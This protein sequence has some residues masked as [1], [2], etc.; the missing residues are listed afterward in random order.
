MLDQTET[1]NPEGNERA[2]ETYD[3][4]V[5]GAG[6]AGLNALY[7]ATDYLPKGAKVLLIDQNQKAGGMWNAAYDYVRL[8]QPHPMF[9]IGDI[10]WPWTKPATYLAKRDEIR[11]HLAAAL[12]PISQSVALETRFGHTVLSC[13]EVE[14]AEGHRARIRFHANDDP[15]RVQTVE[16]ATAIY[17]SGLDYREAEPLALS[18]GSVISIIPQDLRA[19]LAAKPAA[20]V[21]VVG[22]GKTGMDTVLETLAQDPGRPVSLINGTGTNFMNRTKY[23]PT[24]LRRWFSGEPFSRLLRDLALTFDGDNE[25]QTIEHFRRTHSTDPDTPN[26]AFLFA[27]QSVAEDARV[28]KGVRQKYADYLVDV[29]DGPDGPRMELRSGTAEPVEPGSIFVNCTGSYFRRKDLAD[30][31][32]CL[33][34]HRTVLSITPRDGLHYHTGVSGFFATHLFYRGELTDLGL[35]TIDFEA[36]F[37]ESKNAFVGA[38][39]AQAY[40]FHV[41]MVQSLPLPVLNRCLLDLDRWYPLPRR[42]V[43]FLRL[44]A[45]ARADLTHCRAVLDRV[46]AR[47]DIHCAPLG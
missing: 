33:S 44:K 42:L 11:D 16:A 5:V 43:W 34:P 32:P 18:S 22:G 45:T 23:A 20:P 14:T 27:F 26:R 8:H 31:R 17:A 25:D 28:A 6:L 3:L 2:T 39:A 24:G 37:R 4:I 19:T 40:M 12:E 1:H 9:T 30:P 36:L 29:A 46:A 38:V 35:Y 21:V 41:T 13:N 47:F 7:A 10:E 15:S